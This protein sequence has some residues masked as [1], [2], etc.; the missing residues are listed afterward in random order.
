MK[1]EMND[2]LPENRETFE[3][4][5]YVVVEMGINGRLHF[6]QS[7]TEHGLDKV[8]TLPN[9]RIDLHTIN[10]GARVIMNMT[11]RR[12]FMEDLEKK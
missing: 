6:A 9:G 8:R 4:N 12:D 10:E 5:A 3:R 7:V 2:S 11:A 1:F